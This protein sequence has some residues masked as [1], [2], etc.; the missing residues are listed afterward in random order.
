MTTYR[1]HTPRSTFDPGALSRILFT[2]S[3]LL[4]LLLAPR[5]AAPLAIPPWSERADDP[6]W[7]SYI[8]DMAHRMARHHRER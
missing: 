4:A 3:A 6:E 1:I 5:P 2:F 8:R 7:T